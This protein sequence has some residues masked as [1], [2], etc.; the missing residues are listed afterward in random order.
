VAAAGERKGEEFRADLRAPGSRNAQARSVLSAQELEPLTRLSTARSLLAVAQTFG[1]IAA[2]VALAVA[3]W[4][5]AWMLVSIV[6]IGIAQHGLF[7]LAHEAA[8]YRLLP[9]RTANDLLGRFIGMAGGISMCTYRVTHRLHHNNLYTEEDPDTAIHGGYP[10]GERYLLAKLARDIA[11]LN[12]WKTF[13][14][15]FGA[16]AIN[17][18]TN[19]EIRPLDDTSPA[20]RAAA[21]HDRLWVAGFHLAAPL[22]ALAAAGWHGLLL[23]AVLWLLPLVTVLQP[24]LRIRAIFEHGAVD[25]LSS[26]LTAARTNRTWGSAS[27]LLARMVLFPHHVNHHVEHHLYPAVPHYHLPALHRLLVARGALHDAEV[28]DSRDTWRLVYAPRRSRA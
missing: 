17:T 7:I 28:R 5:S 21:R 10:R 2:A 26:P 25:D 15:F 8:H 14:Y 4:P 3:T 20:L 6:A 18:D 11:G 9:D 22:V 12:A 24:I 13:A 27:N 19:R 23:Y 16:P 1:L